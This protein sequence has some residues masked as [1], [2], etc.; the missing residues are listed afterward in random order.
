MPSVALTSAMPEP[1][2]SRAAP[3]DQADPQGDGGGRQSGHCPA[4][5]HDAD[6]SARAQTTDPTTSASVATSSI[7]RLP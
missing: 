6:E 2:A 5:D 3:A 4:D 7:R 1:P